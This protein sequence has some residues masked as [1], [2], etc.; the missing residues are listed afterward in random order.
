M[1]M[2]ILSIAIL[3]FSIVM[4]MY[5]LFMLHRNGQVFKERMKIQGKIF[6]KDENDNYIW[7][8]QIPFLL[9]EMDGIATYDQMMHRFWKKPSS[10]YADFIEDLE[11]EKDFSEHLISER[12][13]KYDLWR[14]SNQG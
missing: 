5:C 10:F 3:C 4:L 12:R 8:M 6:E 11:K 7:S 2:N 1:D 13:R 14:R 9:V